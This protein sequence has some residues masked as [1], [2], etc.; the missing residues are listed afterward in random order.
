MCSVEPSPVF[1]A[2]SVPAGLPA[3]EP[4][5]PST[6]AATLIPRPGAEF[7]FACPFSF[8]DVCSRCVKSAAG[9]YPDHAAVAALCCRLVSKPA[10]LLSYMGEM[11][12]RFR[13]K[14]IVRHLAALSRKERVT[15]FSRLYRRFMETNSKHKRTSSEISLKRTNR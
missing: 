3:A 14:L 10:F 13:P 6:I 7:R 9:L 5:P 12:F 2:E 8:A 15:L 1:I 11:N 4:G